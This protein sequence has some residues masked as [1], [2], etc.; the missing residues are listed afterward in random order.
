MIPKLDNQHWRTVDDVFQ[1]ASEL[2]PE[3]RSAFL[4]EACSNDALVRTKVEAMLDADDSGWDLIEKSALEVAAPLLV[5]GS[6]RLIAG[7]VFGRYQIVSLIGR[8]GMGEV[9]L[10]RD[11]SLN[12]QVALKLLATEYTQHAEITARSKQEAQAAS[13]LNHPN[14]LTIYE[15]GEIDNYQ[16]IAT[17]FVEGETLRE[18]LGNALSLKEALD[19]T[20]QVGSALAAAHQAGIVH[21]DVKPENIMIRPDGYVKLLDFGLAEL[22]EPSVVG[23]ETETTTGVA[24]TPRLMMG[25]IKYASPEQ[26]RGLELDQRSD[27]FSFGVV[28]FE[29][30]TNHS[31]F[32]GA[33]SGALVSA[34]LGHEPRQIAK[35][36]P[37]SPPRLQ[38]IVTQ[39]LKKDKNERYQNVAELLNEL[40]QLKETLEVESRS[41]SGHAT[42]G[43]IYPQSTDELS[44]AR[45]RPNFSVQ[46]V[47]IE[48]KEHKGRAAA[49]LGVF[50][51]VTAALGYLSYSLFRRP[52]AAIANISVGRIT[53]SGRAANAAISPD[54]KYV[55]Y[56]ARDG[57]QRSLWIREVATSTNTQVIPPKS[58]GY[59]GLTFSPDGNYLY[60]WGTSNGEKSALY[61]MPTFGGVP[62][63]LIADVENSNSGNNP[64]SFSPDG[65][66]LTFVRGYSSGESAVV[67]ANADG[68]GE[69]IIAKRKD[70]EF[71]ASAAWAPAAE[72]I[73]C[74]AGASDS[75]GPYAEV[76]QIGLNDRAEERI[77]KQRWRSIADLAWHS[78]GLKL[79]LTASERDG[80]P[81]QIWE[82]SPNGSSRR[83]T[84][85]L[86]SYSG[87]SLT[88]DSS[89]L[90][91]T[92]NE[93]PMNIWTQPTHAGAEAKQ[94]TFGTATK[95]GWSGI[96]W[97]TDNRIVYS[98]NA[99]GNHD[100]WI[101]NADGRNQK[102]LTVNRGSDRFGLSVSPDNR[103]VAF[104]SD[105]EGQRHIWRVSVTDG[106]LKQLTSG[107]GESDPLFWPDGQW[108]SYY[109]SSAAKVSIDGGDQSMLDGA[110][111]QLVSISPD[112]KLAAY[113]VNDPA[114]NNVTQIGIA[115]SQGGA[116]LTI[117]SLPRTAAKRIRWTP[118][119]TAL[120]Y[121]VDPGGV[122]NLFNQPI[123]GGAPQQ[124]TTFDTH[125]IQSF[126]WSPDGKQ[127]AIAR[128][129][130]NHDVVLMKNF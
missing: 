103:Y 44:P 65:T 83:I 129:T 62:R 17:E 93:K 88:A 127:L 34:I 31:P 48:I 67:I 104:V 81:F 84:T 113:V 100:I 97:T 52:E 128:W 61:Q 71:F 35:Y 96:G 14:I 63:K 57:D 115:P 1:R 30:V 89:T 109:E 58:A 68:T 70:Q 27:L 130:A 122:A 38:S 87:L 46:S 36:V 5:D 22:I 37:N 126:A 7:Q 76:I 20:I 8:G 13:S 9:Y 86:N 41:Q 60:F 73:A 29:T 78:D 118:D 16:Y 50:F 12:R 15:I 11:E 117:L 90:V 55:A 116:P 101:M 119:G 72:E 10:A 79:L 111:S 21:R 56:M 64:I 92:L 120:T 77:S 51:V 74:V 98:S 4:D 47:V 108:M 85:D 19:I 91:T 53:T 123:A 25:T 43:P 40:K 26:L 42:T 32:E 39:A 99:S 125:S 59:S 23:S 124:L 69:Q 94:I 49:M 121:I 105:G 45:H 102:Q 106:S 80:Q 24:G 18:R 112:G 75:H 54:G 114:K 107:K 66:R 82:V 33:T 110:F 6:P 95:D 3:L 2:S 28:L